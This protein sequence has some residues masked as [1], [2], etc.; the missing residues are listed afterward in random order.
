MAA[1][2]PAPRIVRPWQLPAFLD[3]LAV[4]RY[5]VLQGICKQ[6]RRLKRAAGLFGANGA[7]ERP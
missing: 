6:N 4:H 3:T 7:S 1:A 5:K 2:L